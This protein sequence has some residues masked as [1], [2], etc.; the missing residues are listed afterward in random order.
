MDLKKVNDKL[1][2]NVY[3]ETELI[4]S[5][6]FCKYLLI[7][8]PVLFLIFAIGQ[9][10]ASLFFEYK[11]DWSSVLIQAVVFAI[12]FRGFHKV[13]KLVNENFKNKYN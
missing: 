6:T 11:F 1:N 13:R 9:Y 4:N 12:F 5:I 8:I 3:E 7:Y 2:R 10:I